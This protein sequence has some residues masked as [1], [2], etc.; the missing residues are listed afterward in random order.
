MP[1]VGQV[2]RRRRSWEFLRHLQQSLGPSCPKHISWGLK[3]SLGNRK[4]SVRNRFHI[5]DV[6]SILNFRIG[7]SLSKK[8]ALT[9]QSKLNFRVASGVATEFPYWVRI[10]DRGVDCRDPVC[11]HRFR[12]LDLRV[13]KSSQQYLKGLEKTERFLRR[14]PGDSSKDT[15]FFCLELQGC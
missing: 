8:P 5:G 6:V 12:C 3:R 14:F 2:T 9:G 13:R 1:S 4:E 11:R 10:V 7:V 15:A